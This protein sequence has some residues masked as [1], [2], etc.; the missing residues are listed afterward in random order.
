[1]YFYVRF[2]SEVLCCD[3]PNT[4]SCYLLC[5]F[6][7][8][9]RP[10]GRISECK[11]HPWPLE[12][13]AIHPCCRHNSQWNPAIYSWTTKC[14][15]IRPAQCIQEAWKVSFSSAVLIIGTRKKPTRLLERHRKF[16]F[17]MQLRGTYMIH[18]IYK[19]F[20]QVCICIS[21]LSVISENNDQGWCSAGWMNIPVLFCSLLFSESFPFFALWSLPK[22]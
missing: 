10:V 22:Q 12:W 5:S 13:R 16:G 6:G 21:A 15:H 3:H 20:V 2:L 4:K 18:L 11:E 14:S 9:Q 8:S 1:M 19:W 7:Y 17:W